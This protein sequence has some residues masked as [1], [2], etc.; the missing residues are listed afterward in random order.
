MQ[1]S[2]PRLITPARSESVSPRAAN[3][4]DVPPRTAPTRTT[5]SRL[6]DFLRSWSRLTTPPPAWVGLGAGGSIG[7]G[8]G[9]ARLDHSPAHD[10]QQDEAHQDV[11]RC[12]RQ[13]RV[14]LEAVAGD[15]DARQQDRGPGDLQGM[16]AGQ[17]AGQEG[18]VAEVEGHAR[19]QLQLGA[20]EVDHAGHPGQGPAD[21]HGGHQE[22]G[23]GK[24]GPAGGLGVAADD[25]QVEPPRRPPQH[26]PDRARWRRRPRRCPCGP[27]YCRAGAAGP[28]RPAA[29]WR[30]GPSRSGPSRARR[31]GRAAGR[32]RRS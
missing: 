26:R 29:G 5:S 25:P 21:E 17:P 16:V 31:S 12:R 3:R 23:D 1:P 13:P 22:S 32:W 7:T 2:M 20:G 9:L 6:I 24:A 4:I 18:D 27:G 14:E 11:H 8:L 19:A 15:G 28:P 10:G 30:A